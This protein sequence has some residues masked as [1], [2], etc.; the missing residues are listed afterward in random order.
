M[1]RSVDS[2]ESRAALDEGELVERLRAR[3]PDS[4]ALLLRRYGPRLRAAARRILANEEDVSDACQDALHSAF[5]GIARFQGRCRLGT[6]L[7]RIVANAARMKL[8]TLRRLKSREVARL[9]ADDEDAGTAAIAAPDAEDGAQLA[10]RAEENRVVRRRIDELPAS[11]RSAVRLQYVDGL[12]SRQ[13]S[14]VLGI[15]V[16]AVKLRVFRGRRALRP[17]LEALRERCD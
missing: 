1:A 9:V 4:F 7:E 13:I 10:A 3:D 5:L 17:W 16:G 14:D 11:L 2:S 6:W 8:R 12:D 15:T